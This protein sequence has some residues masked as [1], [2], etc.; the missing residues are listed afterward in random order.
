M[1]FEDLK[2]SL[3]LVG[4]LSPGYQMKAMDSKFTLG[5]FPDP[6]DLSFDEKKMQNDRPISAFWINKNE[7]WYHFRSKLHVIN[8]VAHRP[9]GL[10]PVL[11]CTGEEMTDPIRL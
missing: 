5:T 6:P 4:F 11:I 1:V 8:D 3:K 10:F 7:V 2:T 9:S